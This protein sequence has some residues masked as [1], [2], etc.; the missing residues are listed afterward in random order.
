MNRILVSEVSLMAAA[1]KTWNRGPSILT[2][3]DL[4]CTGRPFLS[5][6]SIQ[7]INLQK[8]VDAYNIIKYIYICRD[9]Q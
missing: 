8:D 6:G 3:K 9:T 4:V 7:F 1:M 5:W 2:D